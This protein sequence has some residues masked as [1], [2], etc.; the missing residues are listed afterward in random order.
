MMASHDSRIFP[1]APVQAAMWR[2][3]LAGAEVEQLVAVF[4]EDLEPDRVA[5]AWAATVA[6][7]AALRRGLDS[8][9]LVPREAETLLR[10][11]AES[12]PADFEGWLRADR[13]RDFPREDGLPWRAIYWPGS[14]RWVWTFHH[15]LLDGRSLARI[16]A[17]FL[18]RLR[19]LAGDPLAL[20]EWQ[21]AG[22]ATREAAARYFGELFQDVEPARPDFGGSGRARAARCLGAATADALDRAAERAG[23]SAAT[24]VTWAWGQAQARASGVEAI[25][26]G[27]VRAGRPEPGTA[28]F[29]MNTLPLLL[30]R[31]DAG[32]VVD[33]WCALR[34]QMLAL[35]DFETL[36]AEELPA[37]AAW[38][39]VVMVERGTLLAMLGE[40]AA[41]LESLELHEQPSGELNASAYLRPDLR[42]EV[43]TELGTAAA[44][45]LL[46]HW[47]AVVEAAAAAAPDSEARG[48]GELPAE[49][50]AQLAEWEQ[51][52]EPLAGEPHLAD[53]WREVQARHP[54]RD[55]LWSG[56]ESWTYAEIGRRVERLAGGLSR[57]GVRSGDTVAV[58]SGSRRHWPLALLAIASL[59]AVY[60][61]IEPRVPPSRLRAMLR[62]GRPAALLCTRDEEDDFGLPRVCL[63]QDHEPATAVPPATGTLLALLYTSGSTGEPKGVMLEHA[64]VLNE[65]RW[66][67]RAMELGPGD[68]MLQFS[69][70]GFDA[71]LEEM[72]SCLLSGATLVPRPEEVAEDFA[73]FQAFV[74]TAELTVL[75][76][77]TAFWSAWAGW[78]RESGRRVPD[79]VRATIV[80]GERTSERALAD[81]RAAG[82]GI[83]WNS[84]GP[85]EASIVATAQEVGLAWREPGDPPI[86][87]PL[88]G[89][90]V[91]V[92]DPRGEPLP[93]ATGEIWIGGPGV[94][95]GYWGREARTA[96]AFVRR[97]GLRWY[98]SGDLGRWD[99]QGRLRFLGRR[100]D[101]LKIRGQRVEP[102]E[103]IRLLEGFPGVAA[104]HAGPTGPAER[105]VLA[106]WLRWETAAPDGWQGLLRDHLA[107]HLPAASVPTRWAAVAEFLLTER[108]K[109]DRRG[110]PEPRAW[111]AAAHEEPATPTEQRLAR[112]WDELLDCGGVG[113]HDSFFDLGGHSL[114]ALRMFARISADFG[115]PLPMAALMTAPTLAGLAGVIDAGTPPPD[116]TVTLVPLRAGDGGPPLICLHG[117]D[118]GVF[119]YRDFAR[120]LADGIA[121]LTLEAPGLSASG[122]VPARAV[123]ALAGDYLAAIRRQQPRGPYRLAGYSFGGVVAYEIAVQLRRAGER[124]S[125]L[126]L[127]D[128]ENPATPWRK[129]PL[130]ERAATFWRSLDSQPPL[131]RPGLLLGR[132]FGGL[133]THLQVRAELLAVRHAGP[134]RP[135]GRLRALHVR[136]AHAAAMDAYRPAP[137]D[138]PLL[139]FRTAAVDDKFEVAPDYGW[140]GLTPA[141]E[142]LDVPG[143]H[144]TMF[145]PEHAPALAREISNR[146]QGPAA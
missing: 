128:T 45:A 145:D 103:V 23:V 102:D 134:G 94:G 66:A 3:R 62:D 50:R 10:I 70:P 1:L 112:L 51:G 42:L 72:L 98:R 29:S 130:A 107:R 49:A 38:S 69:S 35:R 86:G 142:I 59:G 52:G 39:A 133:R 87:R 111:R 135:H 83:L 80:G 15:A 101:Q 76:L 16:V 139:L 140:G 6:E 22:V 13:L 120:S 2:G 138:V 44:D 17:G 77:P 110:L 81:W 48:I 89:Y 82:G 115:R 122:R 113:R 30:R 64:G 68:R 124:I 74:E 97:D 121:L 12:V 127:F 85:T 58:R 8:G 18:R 53:A 28:G 88:P 14:R 109:L 43:E 26:L 46:E 146:L 75:D 95:P 92:A 65:A 9:G 132:I 25:V 100:D 144:L 5:R 91:R 33:E 143:E 4:R 118:G 114:A 126:G 20:A 90:R 116:G 84:Y 60:L 131:A 40:D 99:P 79:R 36:A 67:A 61:P 54:G 105:P 55:A 106:A 117:G 19:G 129:Y 37:P 104:A 41:G 7:T 119:F 136:E 78:L 31:A 27:Q 34:R 108:G 93:G 47:A 96:A 71:S 56:N 21:P 63:E 57:A 32:P 123:E 141:L 11:E 73:A 125:F 137:L 24:I